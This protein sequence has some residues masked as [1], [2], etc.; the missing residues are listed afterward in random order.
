VL[1]IKKN[2]AGEIEKYKARLVA[3][4]FTQ[5]HGVD[6]YEMY[7]PVARLASFRL[8]IA[9]ANRN[10]WPLES[11]DFDSAYLNSVLSDDEVIYLEQPKEYSK[12]DPRKYVFLLHKALYGLKQGARNW[13]ETIRR[14][15]GEL[16]F[17]RTE[18]DH[19]IFVKT[20]SDG[21]R[22]ILAIH[23]D[24]CM[25]T[26][27]N[28]ALVNETKRKV[29]E[30]YKMTDLGP[31]RWLL[32]IKIERNLKNR[33][34]SLS[35][36]AYIDSILARFNFDDVKPVSTPMDPST[37]LTKSQSPS[38]L[39]DIAKMKN[40]PYHEAVGSLM[41]ASMGTRPD[42]TFAVSTVAQFLENPGAAHWEAVKRIFRYLKGTR[43]MKLVYGDENRDL[44]GWVDA[45]GASQDHRRAISGYVFMVDGGAVSWLSKKQ[46]IVTLSTTEAEYV[47]A[48][49]AV[50]EAVW[51][52]RLFGELFPPI[53][54]IN[55]LTTLHSDNKSAITLA[56]GGSVPCKDETH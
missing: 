9:M 51:L 32:G 42:I 27:M 53:N 35:Q 50:K 43:D 15:L 41:Y 46:E 47:A 52:H 12:G 7:A 18:S 39:A 22:V 29:N 10:N 2:A 54:M 44:Q 21:R 30:K 4:G 25:A 13:Y 23:V 11:F 38:T 19:A 36:H 37:P 45:D 3:R 20:W 17:Q 56:T 28:Q 40:V 49:H 14:A 5:I 26:G 16:G 6:Y 55:K 24:D 33:S 34:I 31:C 48:T 1:R 8:L